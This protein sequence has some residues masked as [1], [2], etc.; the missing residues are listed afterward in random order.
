MNALA[1]VG[2]TYG[3]LTFHGT[4]WL[5]DGL[6]PH[7][8]LKFKSMFAQVNKARA[9]AF[10]LLDTPD[11]ATDILWFT[12]RYPLLV[13]VNTQ[14]RL[15]EGHRRALE[16]GEYAS[17]V[18][19][20]DWVPSPAPCFRPNRMPWVYQEQA[21]DI[22]V[23]FGRL[24]L[25]DDV[26][27][28]KTISGLATAAK[29]Q[30]LP[31]AIVVE[32]QLSE[33][34]V[35][36]YIE[37][38]T[39]LTHHII[40]GRTPY[41]L[42][43]ADLYVFRYSNYAGWVDVAAT[44]VF[45]TVIFDEI[46]Q[47]R[48]GKGTAKGIAGA[49]FAQ[50]AQVKIGLTATPVYNYGEEIWN[51]VEI[52]APGSLGTFYEFSLEWCE[53]ASSGKHWLVKDPPAL[54]AYLREISLALRRMEGDVGKQMPPL[55]VLKHFVAFDQAASDSVADEARVLAQRVL[56][57]SFTERGQ[58]A[59]DLDMMARHATGVGKAVGVAQLVRLLLKGGRK[60][61]LGGW[62]RDVYDIWLRELADFK[63][64]M[65]TG[66][67]TP[68]VKRANKKA[69][70]AGESDLLIMS[71]RSGTGLDGL[72][73]VC[74]TAVAGELDWS[75]LVHKQFF[76]RLRRPGQREVVDGI[77]CLTNE[78]SDPV[79]VELNG[80][81][82]A[83]AQG[84]VDPFLPIQQVVSDDSRIKKLAQHYLNQAQEA[85]PA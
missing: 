1:H 16:R 56:E 72:Q 76:G 47:L 70:I 30:K 17:K 14:A 22:A 7:V 58:A 55:N 71:L 64:L 5:I 13:D 85:L 80:L 51:I 67:E 84:I 60:V 81:K 82:S 65:F 35:E 39:T 62:H 52:L 29:G 26:G 68:K 21:A 41:E 46:Q 37:P 34:W 78:G 32:A 66:S 54:G 4:H 40:K 25:M 20:A 69:F 9:G 42:P 19:S 49:T 59:R 45:P 12:S 83:Q 24:L 79:L 73:D 61:L 3:R 18:L 36:D 38:F 75:P 15:D 28:G 43:V 27:L 23:E 50:H 8:S 11:I 48:H 63:P 53:M 57:G 10:A 44:G 33:Q 77:Y 74:H 6:P 2:R 31:A